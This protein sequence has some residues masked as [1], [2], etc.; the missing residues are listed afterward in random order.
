MPNA[1]KTFRHRSIFRT[2]IAEMTRFHSA[3]DAL[4]VLMPPPV[5]VQ[6]V[7]DER[8]SL[9]QGEVTF[10]MW[11]GPLPVRWIARHE[12]GSIPTAFVDQ[13]VVGPLASWQ[14]EHRFRTVSQGVE[15]TDEITYAHKP[16]WRGVL[17]RLAFDGLPLRMVFRYRHWRTRRAVERPPHG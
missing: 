10:R 11:L 12:P 9:T 15:L 1:P 16:G 2:T 6:M 13:M 5:I 14:H 4:R 8:T 17:T 3:P 7:R